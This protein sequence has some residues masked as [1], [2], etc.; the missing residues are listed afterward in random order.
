M[1]DN[2]KNVIEQEQLPDE[3]VAPTRSLDYID[4]FTLLI[5]YCIPIILIYSLYHYRSSFKKDKTKFVLFCGVFLLY[6][7]FHLFI[8]VMMMM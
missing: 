6:L 3:P 4:I 8:M 1:N 7:L 5:L 2:S